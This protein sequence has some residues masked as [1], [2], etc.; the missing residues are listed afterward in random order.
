MAPPTSCACPPVSC[1]AEAARGC[2][3]VSL[4]GAGEVSV[5]RRDGDRDGAT[6][7][8]L[9]FPGSRVPQDPRLIKDLDERLARRLRYVS[10]AETL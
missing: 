9:T 1:N 6:P 2:R 10:E 4:F 8:H 5:K 3:Q 7:P